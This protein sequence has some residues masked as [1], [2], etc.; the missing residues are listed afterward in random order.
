[1]A[2]EEQAPLATAPW[3]VSWIK[4]SDEIDQ[5]QVRTPDG[6]VLR[7]TGGY[8]IC[9][10]TLCPGLAGRNQTPNQILNRYDPTKIFPSVQDRSKAESSSAQLLY[11]PICGL[12]LISG[13]DASDII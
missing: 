9:K 12:L 6:F 5:P 8:S 11:N 7:R 13:Y 10:I 3:A 1:M 4:I 2:L